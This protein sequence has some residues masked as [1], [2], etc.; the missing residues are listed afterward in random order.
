ME[1]I[2]FTALEKL[3]KDF[4]RTHSNNKPSKYFCLIITAFCNEMDTENYPPMQNRLGN[5]KQ[6]KHSPLQ[7]RIETREC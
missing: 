6:S 5:L 7:F 1:K 3:N 4:A 2:K